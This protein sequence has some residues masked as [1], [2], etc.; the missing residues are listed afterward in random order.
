MTDESEAKPP[1]PEDGTVVKVHNPDDATEVKPADS[2]DDATV[3]VGH[4]SSLKSGPPAESDGA[5]GDDATRVTR[6]DH[7]DGST[8]AQR[9]VPE[10]SGASPGGAQDHT[11]V[12]SPAASEDTA[13][14]D[15]PARDMG[16]VTDPSAPAGGR[17]NTFTLA[18]AAASVAAS[19]GGA[20]RSAA[21]GVALGIATGLVA[22]ALTAW[23][24][25]RR[26]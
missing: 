7:N 6:S 19:S 26:H 15:T 11:V 4:G 12:H 21:K 13:A 8:F 10:V 5:M 25:L 14:V 23:W 16:T 17:G 22:F 20:S 1:T 18:S 3:M 9:P 2:D 24:L